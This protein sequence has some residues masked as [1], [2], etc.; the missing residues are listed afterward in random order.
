MRTC[1]HFTR[2]QTCWMS[3]NLYGKVQASGIIK[4]F[5]SILV[6]KGYNQVIDYTNTCL[7][8]VANLDWLL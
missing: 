7:L 6:V 8:L 2:K 3:M 5:K 4:C 1:Q